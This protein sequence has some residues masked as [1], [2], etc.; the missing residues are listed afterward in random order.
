MNTIDIEGE[1][2]RAIRFAKATGFDFPLSNRVQWGCASVSFYGAERELYEPDPAG[3]CMAFIA[4]VVEGG[5]L[6]DLCA[7][8]A[9]TDHC[10]TRMGLGHGLG[11]D[12]IEKARMRCCDLHLLTSAMAWLRYPLASNVAAQARAEPV[13]LFNLSEIS[14]AL[15]EVP[16]F[17]CDSIELME[18]V[19]ALLPPSQRER[20][21]FDG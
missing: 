4:P 18:R 1:F 8:D 2:W 20:V 5:E 19:V 11:L 10:A 12:A 15:D 17:T 14:R 16:K 7:I 9:R 6:L 3:R 13:Y 21:Q